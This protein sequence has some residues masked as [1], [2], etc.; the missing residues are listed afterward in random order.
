MN[1]LVDDPSRLNSQ[2]LGRNFHIAS[3][4]HFGVYT[5]TR[6]STTPTRSKFLHTTVKN[7]DTIVI[8][9]TFTSVK[10]DAKVSPVV[11][12]FKVTINGKEIDLTLG[13]G[14]GRGNSMGGAGFRG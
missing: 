6:L 10:S 8:E 11:H 2:F 7:G 3:S 12:P 13:T 4:S 9:G 14:Y 1:D 5:Q